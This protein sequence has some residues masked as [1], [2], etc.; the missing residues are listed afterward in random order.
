MKN[1]P[2]NIIHIIM[3]DE[4]IIIVGCFAIDVPKWRNIWSNWKDIF[5]AIF[6]F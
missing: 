5:N 1:K 4:I 3:R 2:V 6:I